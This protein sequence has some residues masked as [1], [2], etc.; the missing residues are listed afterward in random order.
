MMSN[1]MVGT[2]LKI[3]EIFA[4]IEMAQ[5]ARKS[6]AEEMWLGDVADRLTSSLQQQNQAAAAAQIPAEAV[7]PA[8][9]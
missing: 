2:G 9:L 8:E 5:G 1:T 4:L 3:E 7:E 6:R